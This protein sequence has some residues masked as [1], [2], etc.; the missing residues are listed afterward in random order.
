[1]DGIADKVE[2]LKAWDFIEQ[3]GKATKYVF[4]ENA[5]KGGNLA[6]PMPNDPAFLSICI[7]YTY[8]L[9]LAYAY[10]EWKE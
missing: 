3:P 2:F 9:Q 8:L 4:S 7:A 6:K 5:R 1:M 10:W